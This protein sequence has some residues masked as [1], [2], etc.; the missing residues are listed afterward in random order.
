M[1]RQRYSDEDLVE[2][3]IEDRTE[4]PESGEDTELQRRSGPDVMRSVDPSPARERSEAIYGETD[5]DPR[6]EEQP[7]AHRAGED[8]HL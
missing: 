6:R 7:S 8:E 1:D 5:I 3:E 2:R 4:S